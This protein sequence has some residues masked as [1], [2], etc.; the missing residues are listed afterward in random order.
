MARRRGRA[1]RSCGSNC[2]DR[3]SSPTWAGCKTDPDGGK[4]LRRIG[5]ARMPGCGN[6]AG[7]DGPGS[8]IVAG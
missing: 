7:P 2:A 1:G 3:A 4:E 6:S 8:L 5:R